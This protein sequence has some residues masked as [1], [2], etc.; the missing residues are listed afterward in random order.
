MLTTVE[1]GS[2]DKQ[3]NIDM[4]E[5]SRRTETQEDTL[6]MVQIAAQNGYPLRQRNSW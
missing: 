5:I 4:A 6:K 2:T 1:Q 3:E